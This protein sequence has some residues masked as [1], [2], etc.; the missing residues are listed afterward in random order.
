M[1]IISSI[2][3]LIVFQFNTLAQ[4]I[5]WRKQYGGYLNDIVHEIQFVEGNYYSGGATVVDSANLIASS[6][7][8]ALDGSGDTTYIEIHDTIFKKGQFF[9]LKKVASGKFLYALTNTEI[10]FPFSRT[11]VKLDTF[12]QIIW[13]RGF[14]PHSSLTNDGHLHILPDESVI[15]ASERGNFSTYIDI[16]AMRWDKDGN[17]LWEKD[18]VKSGFEYVEHIDVLWDGSLLLSGRSWLS[19]NK[20]IY[21]LNIDV[22]GDTIRSGNV[23]PAVNNHDYRNASIVQT[24]TGKYMTYVFND[25]TDLKY[26]MELDS[27][28]NFIRQIS[29]EDGLGLPLEMEDGTFTMV[30]NSITKSRGYFQRIDTGM[31]ITKEIIDFG[32]GI[33]NAPE[34]TCVAFDGSGHAVV[35]G[36]LDFFNTQDRDNFYFVG[37]QDVGIPYLKSNHCRTPPT[38]SAL[39]AFFD[40]GTDSVILT[41]VA[42]SFLTYNQEVYKKWYL[43]DGRSFDSESLSFTFDQSIYPDSFWVSLIVTD[44]IYCTDT[45]TINIYTNEIIHNP[46]MGVAPNAGSI[47][48]ETLNIYPNPA[49]SSITVLF[50]P[51]VST[52]H[53]KLL[54]FNAVGQLQESFSLQ[55]FQGNNATLTI[56]TQR[57]PRGLYYMQF[58]YENGL[59][60]SQKIVLE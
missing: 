31:V 46:W 54:V 41:D 2:L 59:F 57:Y 25:G 14:I 40:V 53:S 44:G 22:N 3:I 48:E 58:Q 33:D 17:L 50:S 8:I 10:P 20:D 38:I 27:N 11:L 9:Q 6:C 55:H 34:Y 23:F 12:R 7:L 32:M 21:Y 49:T 4:S 43:Q 35:G 15:V 24:S 56:D 19:T 36:M 51:K 26:V 5:E 60:K 37:Y 1:R 52:A 28:F 13:S 30:G 47:A 45:L 16:F 29:N 42:Q 18:Y 39:S